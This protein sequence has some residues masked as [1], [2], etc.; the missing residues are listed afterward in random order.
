MLPIEEADLSRVELV[1]KVWIK[2]GPLRLFLGFRSHDSSAK[3]YIV[4]TGFLRNYCTSCSKILHYELNIDKQNQASEDISGTTSYAELITESWT[5]SVINIY[6]ENTEGPRLVVD[7]EVSVT[8]TYD[9]LDTGR[10]I[11]YASDGPLRLRIM[12][13]TLILRTYY[14]LRSAQIWQVR[15]CLDLSFG[16]LSGF[17]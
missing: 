9:Y 8:F 2:E 6:G 3:C 10:T 16:L 11:T 15:G 14:T 13:V 12:L 7:D 5:A 17:R 1:Q 4:S